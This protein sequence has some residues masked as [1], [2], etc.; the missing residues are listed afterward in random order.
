MACWVICVP[1]HS[2]IVVLGSVCMLC[3]ND[4]MSV[5]TVEAEEPA[6]C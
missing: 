3:S 5:A 1:V 6:S 4:L 2:W